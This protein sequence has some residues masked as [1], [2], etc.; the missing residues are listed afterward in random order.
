M[1]L[2]MRNHFSDVMKEMLSSQCFGNSIGH[3]ALASFLPHIGSI[4]SEVFSVEVIP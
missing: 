3:A 1:V 2:R 4:S